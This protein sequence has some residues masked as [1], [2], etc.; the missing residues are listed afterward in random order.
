MTSCI[1]EIF[2]EFLKY[3]T[4]NNIKL[5]IKKI[6]KLKKKHRGR[7]VRY[8]KLPSVKQATRIYCTR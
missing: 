4:I 1:S 2:S 7:G 5:N 6:L 8:T 3:F